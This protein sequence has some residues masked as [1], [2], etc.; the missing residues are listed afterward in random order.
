MTRRRICFIGWGGH[1]HVERWA[2]HFARA[3]DEVSVISF[4][5]PGRY[6]P[7]VRQFSIGGRGRGERWARWRMAWL[8][9]RLAPDL[10]HVHWAH[11]AV[12]V[13]A[14]WR[15]PL[16][17]SA[18]GSDIYRR[19]AF[20]DTEWQRL[21]QSLRGCE[22]VTCDSQDLAR[23]IV[24]QFEVAPARVAVIQWGVD[25]DVFQP[26]GSDLRTEFGLAG[27]EVVFSARNFTP[28][29]NQ[30][31]V[32]AAFDALARERPAAFLLMKNYRGDPQV[33]ADV[34]RDIAARGLEDRVRIVDEVPYEKMPALYR[35]ADVTL[36]IPS[37]DG[38]P[39]SVL[40]AMAC[41][42]PTVVC[43]LPSLREWVSDGDTGLLVDPMDV[44]AIARSLRRVLDDA[45][46]RD[47][48]RRN[49]R[50]R[51]CARASQRVHMG[52]AGERYDELCRG[53][54][55]RR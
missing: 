43:D 12:P 36:S 38:A 44:A 52:R 27:R 19:E 11:F 9:W 2:G 14:V 32:V 40:E 4:A 22:L 29:Y 30:D 28:L 13:R 41:G 18:W 25:T 24:E 34:R 53:A 46:L 20:S 10:V 45:P 50:E 7:G 55:A 33:L 16:V 17:V 51:V 39:M 37:S 1:V 23:T 26:G 21:G 49:A 31:K 15:G 47:R 6:P 54:S 3:G 8:L 48:M 5:G 35:T 42:S